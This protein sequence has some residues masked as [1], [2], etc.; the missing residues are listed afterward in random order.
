[1]TY[2]INF[3]IERE[4]KG[5]YTLIS[6]LLDFLLA[7]QINVKIVKYKSQILTELQSEDE[8]S[9]LIFL[10]DIEW[11]SRALDKTIHEMVRCNN[12]L[13]MIILF[14]VFMTSDN[15]KHIIYFLYWLWYIYH[16]SILSNISFFFLFHNISLRSVEIMSMCQ[17][18][19]INIT[20][21]IME[22]SYLI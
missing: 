20:F 21:H 17:I 15:I 22:L 7:Y 2:L 19:L 1:M 3:K 10:V 12:P 11:I 4:K 18:Y 13:Y 9:V 5:Q 8:C 14:D 6:Y 16:S